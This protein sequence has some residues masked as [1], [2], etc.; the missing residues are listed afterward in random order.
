[1]SSRRTYRH[2]V[3]EELECNC[4]CGGQA[5]P[6]FIEQLDKARENAGVPFVITSGF[7]C[8]N[9]NREVGGVPDSAH[10]KGLAADIRVSTSHHRYVIVRG[11]YEAGFER[12]GVYQNF[13]HADIDPDKPTKIMWGEGI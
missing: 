5:K 12:L 9:Y 2:F 7:R 11:L 1:M 10:T 4:G 13:I 3:E 6:R 8:E